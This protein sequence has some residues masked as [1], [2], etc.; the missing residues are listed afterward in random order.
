MTRIRPTTAFR[1][2]AI[3]L[4]AYAAFGLIAP[5]TKVRVLRKLTV[6][7][8]GSGQGTVAASQPY[9]LNGSTASLPEGSVVTLTATAPVG[10]AFRGWSGDCAGATLTCNVTMSADR[11]VNA[12]FEPAIK[13]GVDRDGDG[14]RPF[15][16]ATVYSLDQDCTDPGEAALTAPADDCVDTDGAIHPGAPEVVGDHIDQDCDGRAQ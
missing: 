11:T 10:Q 12:Q 13:C 5:G 7:R 2:A 9:V 3:L 15:G 8:I 1:L 4:A 6:N 16:T 14:H